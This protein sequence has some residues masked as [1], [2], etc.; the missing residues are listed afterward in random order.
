MNFHPISS[1]DSNVFLPVYPG[2]VGEAREE[3]AVG[4]TM[5]FVSS[6]AIGLVSEDWRVASIVSLLT[7][8]SG[9]NHRY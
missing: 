8:G 6:L 7:K 2:S 5:C 9:D 1:A 4:L 3:I